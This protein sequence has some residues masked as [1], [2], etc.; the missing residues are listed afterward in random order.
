VGDIMSTMMGC[1]EALMV[2]DQWISELLAAGP[3]VSL[4]G[5]TLTLVGDGV[6]LVLAEEAPTP[7]ATLVGPTWTAES[8]VDANAISS[9]AG[10]PPTFT[11][12]DDDSVD[13]FDGCS[14]TTATVDIVRDALVFTAGELGP[15]C[16]PDAPTGWASAVTPLLSGSPVTYTIEGDLLSLRSA[17]GSGLDLRADG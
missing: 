16:P 11:F 14:S 12:H 4:D 5:E 2:Q 1:D 17:D 9:V 6:T 13:V 8:I 10:E 3:T 15:P 7:T